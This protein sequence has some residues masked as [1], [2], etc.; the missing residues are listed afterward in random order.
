MKDDV[1]GDGTSTCDGDRDDNDASINLD[2]VDGDGYSTN[3]GDCNDEDPNVIPIDEDGDGFSVNCD[4]DCDDNNIH[5]RPFAPEIIGD[6]IDQDCDGE[7]QLQMISAYGHY[8][9]GLNTDSQIRCWGGDSYG[10]C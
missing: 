6:G 2:D 4:D 9:C 5:V 7:D 1:D 10:V 8:N 3:D